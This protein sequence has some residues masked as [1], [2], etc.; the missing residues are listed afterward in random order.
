MAKGIIFDIEEFALYDG[1]GIRKTVFFKGCPLRC[2]W[3]HNPEGICFNKELLVS[4]SACI[5]CKRCKSVCSHNVCVACGMCVTVCPLRLRKVCGTVYD[6][7]DLA[8]E[9]LK[10]RDFLEKN[11]GGITISGGE[12]LAQP[13]FLWELLE[14]LKPVHTAIETSGHA[15]LDT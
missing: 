1:P 9:L 11:N 10:D 15:P 6:A 7:K 5:N 14:R 2:T 13:E 4:K 3:C 8:A 12:P